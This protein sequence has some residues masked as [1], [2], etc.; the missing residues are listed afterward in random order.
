MHG[1]SPQLL[2]L[3]KSLLCGATTADIDIVVTDSGVSGDMVE[4]LFQRGIKVYV[5]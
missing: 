2:V 3:Q 1:H 5:V 4:K